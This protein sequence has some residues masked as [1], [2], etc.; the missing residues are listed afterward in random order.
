MLRNCINNKNGKNRKKK[1][2]II[3]RS[4]SQ[5]SASLY[6]ETPH[7][8]CENFFFLFFYFIFLPN[9]TAIKLRFYAFELSDENENLFPFFFFS[10]FRFHSQSHRE[11]CLVRKK[12]HEIPLLAFSHLFSAHLMLSGGKK[13][14]NNKNR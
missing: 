14:V 10:T 6:L 2:S 9:C 12:Q 5:S 4:S 8:R 11:L 7:K 1:L 3:Y 13:N